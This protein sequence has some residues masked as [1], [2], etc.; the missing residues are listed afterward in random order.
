MADW[1]D[2]DEL[3]I[4]VGDLPRA[5]WANAVLDN[6][7]F[8]Y[9]TPALAVRL[10]SP[11]TIPD[12]TDTTIVWSQA[13][14][15][16]TGQMWDAG[17]ASKIQIVR[18]GLYSVSC[19]LLWDGTAGDASKRAAFLNV[20]GTRRRGLQIPAVNPSEFQF[21]ADTTLAEG[22]EIDIEVRQLSGADLDLLSSG[23]RTVMT[24]RW[25]RALPSTPE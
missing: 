15:D 22:D 8:L 24:V 7:R 6:L 9:E 17:A 13:V 21:S 16:S 4:T 14:W 23:N 25:V 12:A 10:T 19:S 2:P 20:N 18:A 1:T 3:D 11:Q 5:A